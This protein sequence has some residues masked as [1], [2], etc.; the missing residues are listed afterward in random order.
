[1]SKY[2]LPV[3]LGVLK[4][5]MQRKMIFLHLCF[6]FKQKYAGLLLWHFV[7]VVRLSLV[8]FSVLSSGES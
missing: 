4:E 7:F 1:M 3:S 2:L 6:F 8:L 5:V